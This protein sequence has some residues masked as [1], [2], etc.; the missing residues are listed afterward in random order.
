MSGLSGRSFS[1]VGLFRG[2]PTQISHRYLQLSPLVID[3]CYQVEDQGDPGQLSRSLTEDHVIGFYQGERH[4]LPGK[5]EAEE[6]RDI[7]HDH[8]EIELRQ[9]PR[10]EL[11]LLD[12][13]LPLRMTGTPSAAFQ[14]G[15]ASPQGKALP[16]SLGN[17]CSYWD[18]LIAAKSWLTSATSSHSFPPLSHKRVTAVFLFRRRTTSRFSFR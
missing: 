6:A 3:I 18:G 14:L 11:F 10:F 16:P 7:R 8:G 13:G 12:S 5:A 4:E 17:A 2:E 15:R 1:L 9:P